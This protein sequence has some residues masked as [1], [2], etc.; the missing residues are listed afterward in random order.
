MCYDSQW[1]SRCASHVAFKAR[2]QWNDD[3]NSKHFLLLVCTNDTFVDALGDLILHYRV[4]KPKTDEKLILYVDVVLTLQNRIDVSF[5]DALLV[6][7]T[8]NEARAPLRC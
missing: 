1:I 6:V 5:M 8:F 7:I 3:K 4:R 2:K